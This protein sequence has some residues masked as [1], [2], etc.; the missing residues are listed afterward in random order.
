[1]ASDGAALLRSLGIKKAHVVGVS[2]GGYIAQEMALKDADM[3]ERLVLMATSCGLPLTPRSSGPA[4]S[5]F[6]VI[7]SSRARQAANLE[8]THLSPPP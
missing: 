3:V 8:A 4:A 5:T 2:L 7:I 1:M 6:F